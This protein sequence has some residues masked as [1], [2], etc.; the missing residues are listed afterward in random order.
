MILLH[1][2]TEYAD[3]LDDLPPTAYTKIAIPWLIYLNEDGQLLNFI[4]TSSGKKRD[5]GKEFMVPNPDAKSKRAFGI[6][7]NLLADRADYA[8]GVCK[9]ERKKERTKKL[10][11][12]FVEL[13]QECLDATGEPAVAAVLRFLKDVDRGTIAIPAEITPDQRITFRVEDQLV[14]DLPSIWNF[15]LQ[16]NFPAGEASFRC[17]VCGCSCQPV[18]RHPGAVKGIPGG[19]PSGLALVSA[20]KKAFESYGLEESL[21]APTCYTCAERYLKAINRLLE[22]EANRYRVGSLVYLFWTKGE[23]FSPVSLFQTADPEEV[24]ALIESVERGREYTAIDEEAFYATA[25]SASGGRV[26]VRRWLETTVGEVRQQI[27][28]WFR[29]QRIVESNGEEGRPIPLYNLA[30]SLYHDP[31]K[32]MYPNVPRVLLDV[33]LAGGPL[34]DWMLFQ[35]VKR[36]R[37]E[38]CVT[39]PRAALI[40]MVLLSQKSI[41][42]DGQMEALDLQNRDPAYL[43]GRLLAKLEAVQREAMPGIRETVVDRFF[44]TAS[45]APASVFGRLL[46]GAQSH[47]GKLRKNKPGTYHALQ[48]QLGEIQARLTTF[49]KVLTLEQQ[50]LFALGYYHQQAA[51]RAAARAHRQSLE[52]TNKNKLLN[53]KEV[54]QK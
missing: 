39:R 51:D 29:L 1:R 10:H 14:V 22:S 15:W 5:R 49:P 37:V 41:E 24:K 54:I 13:V 18:K 12:A 44:G 38:Q 34:P 23:G 9:D 35:A 50:G 28:R 11:Q 52:G 53:S 45:S 32:D 43:C 31:S 19:Q 17:I 27:A 7:P 40:K 46:R 21:I 3:R 47:L 16:R 48:E 25:F 33:A 2:L 42:G 6:R 30:A 4:P 26:V 20:N 8:L 36:N